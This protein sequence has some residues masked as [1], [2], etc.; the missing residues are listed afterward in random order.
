MTET[1]ISPFDWDKISANF[2]NNYDVKKRKEGFI[3]TLMVVHHPLYP[4]TA[5]ALTFLVTA[6]TMQ[7][8][9]QVLLTH[10][11][12]QESENRPLW[13]FS[14]TLLVLFWSR[15]VDFARLNFLNKFHS[16]LNWI[17]LPVQFRIFKKHVRDEHDMI[18]L[19]QNV[20]SDP[21]GGWALMWQ[22]H[23]RMLF[24]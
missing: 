14:V 2:E 18:T 5:A 22:Q 15:E 9:L 17:P 13:L 6:C 4:E 23:P 8:F 7:P 21:V 19:A 3:Y 11:Q 24:S 10:T 20:K 12:A 16:L 1:D